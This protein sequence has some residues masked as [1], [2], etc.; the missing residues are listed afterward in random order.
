[1][2]KPPPLPY[3]GYRFKLGGTLGVHCGALGTGIDILIDKWRFIGQSKL[4]ARK[5]LCG[6][7]DRLYGEAGKPSDCFLSGTSNGLVPL[8]RSALVFDTSN[9]HFFRESALDLKRGIS[10]WR[11]AVCRMPK[12]SRTA[13]LSMPSRWVLRCSHCRSACSSDAFHSSTIVL[14]LMPRLTKPAARMQT[15]TPGRAHWVLS[16]SAA[17]VRGH[18]AQTGAR[19]SITAPKPLESA[20]MEM[21]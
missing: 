20:R 16:C 10:S 1:M 6:R 14:I 18:A 19:E 5:I 8:I 7:S 12:T 17:P 4:H 9:R 11:Q 3:V 21:R 15:F 2:K 13:V